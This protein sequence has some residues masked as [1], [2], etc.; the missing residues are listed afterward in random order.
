MTLIST[1]FDTVTIETL[2]SKIMLKFQ[3]VKLIFGKV[4]M[5]KV[6]YLGPCF[7]SQLTQKPYLF[8]VPRSISLS[9]FLSLTESFPC[10]GAYISTS[11]MTNK[12]DG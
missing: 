6:I 3:T 11:L 1:N 8:P 4:V 10:H 9:P 7:S 5:E 12:T 2:A